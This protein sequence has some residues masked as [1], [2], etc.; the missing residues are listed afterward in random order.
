MICPIV[1]SITADTNGKGRFIVHIAKDYIIA[2]KL[3]AYIGVDRLPVVNIV[4]IIC[5]VVFNNPEILRKFINP[6][7]HK[8]K[9]A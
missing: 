4:Y 6:R 2:D 9:Y 3:R 7:G 1:E 5:A 8:I